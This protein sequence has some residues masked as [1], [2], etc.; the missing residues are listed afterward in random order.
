MGAYQSMAGL[1]KTKYVNTGWDE[2][3]TP[4]K[5]L[6]NGQSQAMP[7]DRKLLRKF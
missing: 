4:S 2:W 6:N 7:I 3:E 5:R 1:S